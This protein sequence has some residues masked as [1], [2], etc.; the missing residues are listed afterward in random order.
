MT[1]RRGE[2]KRDKNL[3]VCNVNKENKKRTC[4]VSVCVRE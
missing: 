2:K 1:E 4:F 3:D